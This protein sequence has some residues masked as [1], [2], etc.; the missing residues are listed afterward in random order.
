MMFTTFLRHP[1]NDPPALLVSLSEEDG[2]PSGSNRLDDF[3]TFILEHLQDEAEE[4]LLMIRN[5]WRD[6]AVVDSEGKHDLDLALA[7]WAEYARHLR[8][9]SG[10][11][12]DPCSVSQELLEKAL[13]ES[14]FDDLNHPLHEATPCLG[15]GDLVDDDRALDDDE[16]R[17]SDDDDTSDDDQVA[18]LF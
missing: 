17:G 9:C 2:W 4:A 5:L 11:A 16:D 14:R 7:A 3:E 10:S 6:F 1:T 13:S 15:F 12:V 18:E 8:P